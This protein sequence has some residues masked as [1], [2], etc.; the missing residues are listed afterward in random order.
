[1]TE[2]WYESTEAASDAVSNI[3]LALADS[4]GFEEVVS[5]LRSA[6]MYVRDEWAEADRIVPDCFLIS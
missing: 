2:R 6:R 4:D 5:A 3:L 1:M